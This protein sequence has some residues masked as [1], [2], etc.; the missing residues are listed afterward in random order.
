MF[1]IEYAEGVANDLA[2][3]RAYERSLILDCIEK[4]LQDNPVQQTRQKKI[5]VGL[6]PPWEYMEPVWELRI[7]EFRI[8]YDVNEEEMNVI[9]RAIRRKPPHKTTE[10]I[11]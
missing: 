4:Q 10:E 8:F 7:G 2:C 5:L 6:I 3:L 11:L 1:R 9:I